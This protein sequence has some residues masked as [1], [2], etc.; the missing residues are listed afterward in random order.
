MKLRQHIR[1]LQEKLGDDVNVIISSNE[2]EDM[3]KLENEDDQSMDVIGEVQECEQTKEVV[4]TEED[5]VGVA[6]VAYIDPTPEQQGEEDAESITLPSET[7]HLNREACT[8][9]T[10][11]MEMKKEVV[12]VSGNENEM[13]EE[14]HMYVMDEQTDEQNPLPL[15][16]EDKDLENLAAVVK[17]ALANH[18]GSCR[19]NCLTLKCG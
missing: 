8:L 15:T 10:T 13:D 2:D 1:L 9:P 6:Q 18:P 16:M 5:L 11:Q 19:I 12:E 17:A 7:D 3:S 14:G 4:S